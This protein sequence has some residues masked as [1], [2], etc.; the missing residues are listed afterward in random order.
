[1]ITSTD[2]PECTACAGTGEGQFDGAICGSCGGSGVQR[3]EPDPDD[4]DIPDPP[5]WDDY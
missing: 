2:I 5:E 3:S 1:M 4:F